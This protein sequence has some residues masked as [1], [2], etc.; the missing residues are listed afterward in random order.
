MLKRR[1]IFGIWCLFILAYFLFAFR[2]LA[3]FFILFT[4]FLTVG[5]YISAGFAK[6]YLS[7]QIEAPEFIGKEKK[8][9]LKIKLKNGSV[10]TI[11]FGRVY[12]KC[13]NVLTK[14][15][16]SIEAVFYLGPKET[17]TLL[18]EIGS[19]HCGKVE[20]QLERL[21]CMD[22]FGVFSSK[23][24]VNVSECVYIVPDY[25]LIDNKRLDHAMSA[26]NGSARGNEKTELT[27]YTPEMSYRYIHWK[28]SSKTEDIFARDDNRAGVVFSNIFIETAVNENYLER[29]AEIADERIEMAYLT[30]ANMCNMGIPHKIIFYSDKDRFFKEISI[31]DINVLQQALYIL[32]EIKFETGSQPT[33]NNYDPVNDEETVRFTAYVT[34]ELSYDREGLSDEQWLIPV[35]R[36]SKISHT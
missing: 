12:L 34:D 31:A 28:L 8:R 26:E 2:P 18:I 30:S 27:E 1:I 16:Q 21:S 5:S 22:I 3:A 7:F 35:Y 10:F 14:E 15:E 29:F 11:F 24:N 20:I 19:I 17:D 25:D 4:F 32:L 36:N 23:K 6:K 13:R 9:L 33:F